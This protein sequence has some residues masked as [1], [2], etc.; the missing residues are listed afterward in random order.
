MN[1]APLACPYC[2]ASV[3]VAP[4]TA[5]GRRVSCPRCGDAFTLLQSVPG[6]TEAGIRQTPELPPVDL[7]R[8][9]LPPRRSNARV[10][11]LI[12]AVMAG[13]AAVALG[14]A[15]K[16]Q[17]DRRANDAGITRKARRAPQPA[18]EE[19]VPAATA[20]DKLEALGYLPPDTA[21]I[22]GAHV[23]DLLATPAGRPL[24]QAADQPGK[25]DLKIAE[26]IG[27]MGLRLEDVDH[28]VAGLAP[29]SG[30]VLLPFRFRVVAR[31]R[32]AFDL[33]QL[34]VRLN[35]QRAAGFGNKGIF[36]YSAPG[37]K[38]PLA[39]YCPDNHTVVIA[40]LDAHLASVPATP[41]VGLAQFREE[42]RTVLRERREPGSQLWAAGHVENGNTMGLNRLLQK[43]PKEERDLLA[44]VRTFGVWVQFDGGVMVKA[45]LHFQD[46]A[47]ARALDELLHAP[48]RARLNLKTAVDG[49]WVSVQLRT[50]LAAIQHALGLSP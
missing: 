17:P 45:S 42:V 9:V 21:V 24:L 50:D 33:E 36:R 43:L 32:E 35:G 41:V 7:G 22:V 44:Q 18:P 19:P 48:E 1:A 14:F 30:L 11:V 47:R 10:L 3:T 4:G 13:M 12:L 16:T 25:M 27:W 38:L 29:D 20:P 39:M 49:P 37:G 15:L 31:T 23:A 28:L 34:R 2:N 26:W 8:V 46:A 40:L 6:E 5:A